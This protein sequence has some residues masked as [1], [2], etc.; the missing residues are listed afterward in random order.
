MYIYNTMSRKKELFVPQKEGQVSM[1][2]CGPT[3]YNFFHI[4]NARPFIV[5]DTL[6]RYL[7]YRGYKVT[8]VQNFTDIDD[9]MIR[10]ANEEGIT[11][12]ELGDRFIQE[13]YT[14]YANVAYTVYNETAGK[15]VTD[16]NVQYPQIVMLDDHEEGTVFTITA[17]S[18]K[19]KFMP[20][21]ATCIVDAND[22][23]KITFPIKQ[24]GGITA[25]FTQTDN[26]GIVGMLYDGDGRFV[27]KYEY[28]NAT[29]TINELI[30]GTYTLV[31]MGSSSLFNA[32]GSLSQFTE[33]GLKEGVDY[34]KNQVEVKS[35]KM[36][37][38]ANQLIP[39]LDETKLYYTGSNTRFSVN[40]SQITAGQYLTLRGQIDFKPIYVN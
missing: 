32:I 30:D 35:G 5:F 37:A 15:N 38:I 11:V 36:T 12:K 14:D 39:Y 4:G 2:A 24:L 22:N 27:S 33:A 13:Y 1:Y 23:A 34:V 17:T 6:R 31:T 8:F 21:T 28:S 7:E 9:K 18:K 26:T 25:S 10:R 16:L 29:L 3:V 19:N 20:V 40:K